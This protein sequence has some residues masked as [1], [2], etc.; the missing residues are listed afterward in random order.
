MR[1][2]EGCGAKDVCI[3]A[4]VYDVRT[5]PA[6]ALFVDPWRLKE[7]GHIKFEQAFSQKVK[8]LSATSAL[9]TE[10]CTNLGPSPTES[11]EMYKD[12]EINE[13]HIRLLELDLS[14]ENSDG[15]SGDGSEGENTPLRVKLRRVS[16]NRPGRFW[17][18]SYV[19]GDKPAKYAPRLEVINEVNDSRVMVPITDSLWSC[20]QTLRRKRIAVPLWADAICINQEDSVE[21]AFQ[22][23][24]MGG[25]YGKAERVLIWTG[26]EQGKDS[27]AIEWLETLARYPENPSPAL[28]EKMEGSLVEGG[29]LV[30]AFMRRSW[31]GRTWTIQELVFGRQVTVMSGE[32]E[33]EWDVFMDCVIKYETLMQQAYGR[34]GN[35]R[36]QRF[37]EYSDP[38]FS[39]HQTRQY[40]R[41]TSEQ[42]SN[43]E[44]RYRFL[45][46]VELF[47]YT[48]S[49]IPRDKMFAL[50]NLAYD[51]PPNEPAFWPDYRSDE[52]FIL[53]N[54]ARGLVKEGQ[55]LDLMY[56]AGVGKG[57]SFCS[58][59]PD[60][61]NERGE[62][63]Y[64]PSISSWETA[65]P[66][67]T[68]EPGFCAGEWFRA[69]ASVVSPHSGWSTSAN[70]MRPLVL[71]ITGKM[72]D[73][74]KTCD[75]LK[76]K[77]G[78]R[79]IPFSQTL[80]I[81]R[82]SVAPLLIYP[83]LGR[84]WVDELTVK[85]LTGNA[86]GPQSAAPP[87]PSAMG[88]SQ[89]RPTPKT[90]WLQGFERYVL[91]VH[92][93]QDGS[94]FEN[95]PAEAR[96]AIVQFWT[97]VSAFMQRIPGAAVCTTG[98]GYAGIFP[99][100]VEPDDKIFLPRGSKVPF[101]L[102]RF[103]DIE[104]QEKHYRLIGECYV[105]GIMYHEDTSVKKLGD[106]VAYI[107]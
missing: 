74:V 50:L 93:G 69:E 75:S 11:G 3:L 96:D 66:P 70:G 13:Q 21:K 42:D 100:Q 101:V 14:H 48:R 22:V 16:I 61:M 43:R 78:G 27:G 12:I 15:G 30:D 20:L 37:L 98:K 83:N 90:R 25:L 68:D 35:Q 95:R 18:I 63:H 92:P 34:T 47:Y 67:W 87:L 105:H 28:V 58:W 59:I 44:L 65:S 84:D 24:R 9:L 73:S 45:T 31:F 54:Y 85:C 86:A 36:Q 80:A 5:E 89:R 32:S 104:S 71:S 33:I 106:E 60:L 62:D 1:L 8:V 23:R 52:S 38:V 29:R 4:R 91:D 39:L 99:G 103:N 51:I 57:T 102:R 2:D 6:I 64:A 72:F 26:N 81:F 49:S 76:L 107:V 79:S 56:R 10:R 46:L 7:G 82:R 41:K 97:T 53:A 77:L 40:Y 94:E 19:W 17:A 88:R 55:V